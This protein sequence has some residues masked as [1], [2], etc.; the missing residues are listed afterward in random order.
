M[1]K[2]SEGSY[3]D[4]AKLVKNLE[5]VVVASNLRLVEVT[6]ERDL[7]LTQIKSLGAT[8]VDKDRIIA[9]YIKNERGT[10]ARSSA[11]VGK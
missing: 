3:S 2:L 5:A 4:L 1:T 6:A 7:A 10:V 8:I 11:S 9:A